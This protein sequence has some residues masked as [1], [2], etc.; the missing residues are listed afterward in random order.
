MKRP[1]ESEYVSHVSYT[2]ALEEYCNAL[3][4]AGQEPVATVQCIRGIIIG[5]LDVM[6]P[7]GTKLYTSPPRRKPLSDEQERAAFE[8]FILSHPLQMFNAARLKEDPSQYLFHSAQ[9]MWESWRARAA[10]GIKE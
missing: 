7:V 8:Q 6:Q 5:F 2:R 9:M 3:E 10:H 1:I 4:N